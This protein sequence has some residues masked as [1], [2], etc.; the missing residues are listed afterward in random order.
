MIRQDV[1]KLA[2]QHVPKY[3]DKGFSESELVELKAKMECLM[4]DKKPHLES[5]LTALQ[6]AEMMGLP[7]KDLSRLL[8]TGFRQNFYDFIN[9]Y[10]VEEF[11][12]LANEGQHRNQT[13][14]AIAFDAGFNSKT[15]FNNAFKKFTGITPSEYLKTL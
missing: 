9:S 5:T 10:R 12:R 6:L 14:L 7:L 4:R 3:P 15:T 11:M 1:F 2:P 8:N 13:L